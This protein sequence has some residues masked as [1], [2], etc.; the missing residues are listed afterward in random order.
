MRRDPRMRAVFAV[1][2]ATF[3]TAIDATIVDTAMPRIVGTLGGFARMT[4]LVTAYLLTSTATVPLY[5]KLA[6]IAGRKRTFTA[7][8]LLFLTG[9]A[10]CG[11]AQNMTQLILF[12]GLQG[13]GAGAILPV[14]QTLI[15]DLFSPAERARMQGWFSSV[16]G[17]SALIGPLVGGL[18]VDY[19]SWRWLF[20]INLP[21]GAVALWVL[22]TSVSEQ[23]RP[24]QAPVDWLGCA[25]L[26]VGVAALIL[27]LVEGGVHYPWGSPPILGLL[28]LAAA[29]LALFAWQER[30][31]PD[32]MLPPD[33]FRDRT[34]AVANLTSFLVGG[35]FY[36]TTV[37]LPLWA[38]GVQGYSATRSGASLLWLSIGWPLAS[39]YGARYILRVGQR[40]AALVGL[41]TNA[42]AALA[43]N[44][45]NRL[46]GG[47]PEVGLAALTFAIGAGMGFATL[48]FILGVQASVG[49]ERRGVAT[50]SLQFIRT[51][52]GLVW[53]AAMGAVL[54]RTVTAHLAGAPGLG[55]GAGPAADL[56]NRLLDPAQRAAADPAT[57]A[58]VQEA[59]AAGLRGVHGVVLVAA[60]LSLAAALLYP[61]R[62]F[63]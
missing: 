55:P 8:A 56:A 12:R 49:W 9:S 31:H 20:F 11:L 53:V 26:T 50:A 39:V 48:S 17:L 21:L 6:D 58:A 41:A 15:G 43:L 36:G 37:F 46:P 24:R 52:G 57:L 3:L 35:V 1:M 19:L 25:L 45:A 34:V 29:C 33:L 10:L 13:L 42:A 22:H 28:G 62:R 5:G 4:W 27:A 59:L 7:G 47:I 2:L 51:L 30:R 18:F 38:Q 32:P 16:W 60:A 61:N 54:N 14:V 63:G 40:P 23:V 44:L